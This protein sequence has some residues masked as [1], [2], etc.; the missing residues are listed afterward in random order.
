MTAVAAV[1]DFQQAVA[2]AVLEEMVLMQVAQVLVLAAL[3]A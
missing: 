3:A 2:V 1:Q